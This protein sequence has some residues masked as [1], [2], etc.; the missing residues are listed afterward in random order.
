MS[1]GDFVSYSW[2][3]MFTQMKDQTVQSIVSKYQ[4]LII[5]G[6]ILLYSLILAVMRGQ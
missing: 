5:V 6:G 4:A 1:Q 3:E 2:P